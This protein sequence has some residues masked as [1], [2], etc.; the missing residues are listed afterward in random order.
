MTVCDLECLLYVLCRRREDDRE[1]HT[2]GFE[3]RQV[4][5]IRVERIGGGVD[6]LSD[7]VVQV[8]EECG[9]SVSHVF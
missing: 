4:V 5:R 2:L 3:T 7:A 1:G 9:A 6:P 8:L